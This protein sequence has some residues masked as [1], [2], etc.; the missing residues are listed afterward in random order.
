MAKVYGV[1]LFQQVAAL[2]FIGPADIFSVSNMLHKGGRVVTIA[3]TKE[4]ILCANGVKIIP[5]YDFS[6][7][8]PLDI[9]LVPGAEALDDAM[10][11]SRGLEW[12]REQASEV[13]FVAAVCTGALIIQKAGLLEG[14]RATTHWQL[15]EQL[16]ADNRTEVLPDMR[17]VRD[18][19]IITAQG[20]SAGIDMALWLIGELDTPDHSRQVR[21]ILQYDPAPPY[22]AE[23]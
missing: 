23:V 7:A 13:E 21:K 16:A 1:Y 6:T 3:A 15:L 17:Y 20:I 4:P 2:D 19:Q 8:P 14:K 10:G 11:S 18:G 12:I 5:D 9:L 22:T